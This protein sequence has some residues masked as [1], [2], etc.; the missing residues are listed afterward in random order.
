[1][2][3]YQH[4]KYISSIHKTLKPHFFFQNSSTVEFPMLEAQ[5]CWSEPILWVRNFCTF[6]GDFEHERVSLKHERVSIIYDYFS[7]VEIPFFYP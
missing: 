4:P 7:A 5:T 3:F 1:M 2:F 6:T